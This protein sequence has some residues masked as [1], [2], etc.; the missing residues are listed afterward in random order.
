MLENETTSVDFETLRNSDPT[1]EK[2]I[3]PHLGE[4]YEDLNIKSTDTYTSTLTEDGTVISI[5]IETLDAFKQRN[6]L[7]NKAG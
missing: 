4:R 7:P 6:E 2:T 3:K 5:E 1:I